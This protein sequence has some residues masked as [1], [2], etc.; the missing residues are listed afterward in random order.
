[1]K[2]TFIIPVYNVE[3]YLDQCIQSVVHAWEKEREIILVMGDSTDQSNE[4]CKKYQS[5][6]SDIYVITQSHKGLSNARNCGLKKATGDFVLF[7]D[8]DDY[9]SS[10]ALKKRLSFLENR[11]REIDVLVSDYF[12][13]NRK[14]E[15]FKVSHQICTQDDS[16][17]NIDYTEGYLK[18]SGG[19]WNVWRYIYRTKF[20]KENNLS[21]V[22]GIKSEDVLFTIQV[23]L[24]ARYLG[25]LHEPYYYYRVRRN[26]A[27]TTKIDSSYIND[28]MYVLK[29]GSLETDLYT[30]EYAKQIQNKLCMEYI[31][32]F[33]LLCEVNKKER[34]KTKKNYKKYRWI[35]KKGTRVKFKLFY[36]GISLVGESIPAIILY[37]IRKIRR[38]LSW[39]I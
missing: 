38:K 1:M 21:F 20:L 32:N 35:L 7:I 6:Y 5:K 26:G 18:S 28:L 37:K 12:S 14:G 33:P 22:E 8:S 15:V 23:L 31:L 2:V 29:E 36:L 4:I 34:K 25:Y 11:K 39:S 24:K 19:I 13:V 30:K 16:E 3:L 27:L 9:I 17:I 10:K